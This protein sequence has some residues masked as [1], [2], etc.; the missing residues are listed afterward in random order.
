MDRPSNVHDL[1]LHDGRTIPQLGLGVWQIPDDETAS[2]VQTAIDVGYRHLDT[3]RI[4]D[5]ERG[6]GD[7][8]RASGIDRDDLFVTTKLWNSDQG[9]DDALRACDASLER[10]GLDHVDLYLIHWPAPAQDHYV[11]AWRALV[12]LH[13]DGRARSI[14]VSNFHAEHLERVVEETGVVPVINQVELHPYFQQRELRAVHERLGIAT[15]A[16]SPLGQGGA[17]LD[18]PAL[19]EIASAHGATPA[20]VVIAWHL[21]TGNVV[22]PKSSHAARIAE[23]FAS[24]ELRL[25]SEELGRIDALDRGADG[26]IGPDPACANF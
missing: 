7:G 9:F 17:L 23:N 14:G 25:T 3:A 4:Y 21:A 18:E 11:D 20:Q 15:E 16:W 19:Q 22:I 6:V 1:R 5:N 2:V 26:R 13:E 12:R 10:L 24:T 8:I